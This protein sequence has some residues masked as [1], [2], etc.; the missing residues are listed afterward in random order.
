MFTEQEILPKLISGPS[1]FYDASSKLQPKFMVHMNMPVRSGADLCRLNGE[2]TG[3]EYLSSLSTHFL[4][5]LADRLLVDSTPARPCAGS[6]DLP[7]RA[8]GPCGARHLQVR[9]RRY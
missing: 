9:P 7:G 5:R 4:G 8:S 2:L 1:A 3:M 6:A